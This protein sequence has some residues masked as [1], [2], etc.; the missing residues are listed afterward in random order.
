MTYQIISDEMVQAFAVAA[1][2]GDGKFAS[3]NPHLQRALDSS[4]ARIAAGLRAAFELRDHVSPGVAMIAAER[5]R[6][7]D[8]EGWT[9]EHD[10]THSQGE[11]ARAAS[12]Y[13]L[14]TDRETRMVADPEFPNMPVMS[15]RITW[16]WSL[17]WWKPKDRLRNLAHAGALIAAEIERH[18][19]AEA[20]RPSSGEGV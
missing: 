2:M 18:L 12:C 6:Q 3:N 15:N 9:P 10:D 13:A 5:R 20:R 8:E 14:G 1:D 11:M 7:V 16:P 17:D 19:R 4:K